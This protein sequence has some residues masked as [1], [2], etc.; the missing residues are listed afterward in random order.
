MIHRTLLTIHFEPKATF[1]ETCHAGQN[2]FGRTATANINVTIVCIPYEAVTSSLKL[3]V[4]FIEY[5]VRNSA[6]VGNLP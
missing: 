2:S 3:T 5:D 1:H 6:E 4:E